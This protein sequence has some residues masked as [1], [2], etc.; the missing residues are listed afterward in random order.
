MRKKNLGFEFASGINWNAILY[1][2]VS[3]VK[4]TVD[5][6]KKQVKTSARV[7]VVDNCSETDRK[8]V[9]SVYIDHYG[10]YIMSSQRFYHDG[11]RKKVYLNVPTEYSTQ[12]K[13]RIA[14][15]KTLLET[16]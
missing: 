13:K 15:V 4:H 12:L 2:K 3:V 9:R 1:G 16:N 8:S 5:R 14:E 10:P 6:W 11:F 7:I